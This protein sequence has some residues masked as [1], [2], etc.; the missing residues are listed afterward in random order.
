[1]IGGADTVLAQ[2]AEGLASRGFRISVVTTLEP[3]PSM[4]DGSAR[5]ERITPD[6]F[7]LPRFLPDDEAREDFLFHLLESRGTNILFIV[8]SAFTYDLLPKIR[9]RFPEVRV[10][11]QLFNEF[12]HLESNR[13][14]RSSI[15]LN[16]V[17]TE[18]LR[19]LLVQRHGEDADRVRVIHHGVDWSGELDPDTIPPS[20][21]S[22]LEALRG[23]HTVAFV[24]RFSEEKDPH[25]FVDIAHRLR[26]RNDTGFLMIG[27]GPLAD[28]VRRRIADRRMS[29]R[30]L[31]RP[32]VEDLRPFLRRTDVL[33]IPSR[34]E[35]IPILLL[36]AFALGIPVVA[37]RV[38]GVPA[39]IEDG[40]NGFLCPPGE[41]GAF[42]SRIAGLLDDPEARWRMGASGREQV[43]SRFGIERMIREYGDAFG[44]LAP[45]DADISPS[46]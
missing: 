32:F 29:D 7:H 26:E 34:I 15:D 43:R 19:D 42:A 13:R 46:R 45:K 24:G 17:A 25:L 38:G 9:A 37:S 11:D 8:G 41:A 39:V 27:D 10:V 14:H 35:G 12:G 1:V 16:I 31:V 36:E 22:G 21:D 28:P 33:V 2:I 23:L 20:D 5:Y 44:S 6:V 18:A 40:V 30:I 3:L 4:G